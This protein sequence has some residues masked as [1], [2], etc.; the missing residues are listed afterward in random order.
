LSRYGARIAQVLGH[1]HGYAAGGVIGEPVFGFGLTSGEPYSFGERGPEFVSPLTGPAAAIGGGGGRTVI[2]V[3]P[4]AQ[5]DEREIAAL[6]S[7]E[8]AW[9]TAGGYS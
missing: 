3:Y 8:L 7:R 1:G 4:R 2:N 9:A 5:Q 6:V